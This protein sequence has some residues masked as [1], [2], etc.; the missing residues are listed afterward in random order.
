MKFLIQFSSFYNLRLQETSLLYF[1]KELRVK[2]TICHG[3]EEFV[4]SGVYCSIDHN[5]VTDFVKLRFI[6]IY[7]DLSMSLRSHQR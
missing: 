7:R 5:I 1:Y 4:I 2:G 6:G 3:P